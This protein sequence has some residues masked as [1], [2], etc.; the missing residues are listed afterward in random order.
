M[1]IL[2]SLGHIVGFIFSLICPIGCFSFSLNL[3]S[4]NGIN[5]EKLKSV[6]II[7]L[8]L[9]CTTMIIVGCTCETNDD[10]F[11]HRAWVDNPQN[12]MSIFDSILVYLL[13]Y[14]LFSALAGISIFVLIIIGPILTIGWLGILILPFEALIS[15]IAGKRISI[16]DKLS[17]KLFDLKQ[18]EKYLNKFDFSYGSFFGTCL[19]AANIIMLILF[20]LH[21]SNC[22]TII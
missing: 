16:T 11:F 6:A 2:L 4:D 22:V 1:K 10:L 8:L 3:I 5:K 9:L 18:I 7:I 17:D 15:K 13:L 20:I 12:T 19:L 14:S 21:C